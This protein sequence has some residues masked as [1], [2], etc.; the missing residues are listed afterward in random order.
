MKVLFIRIP[1]YHGN[2]SWT[3]R[4]RE[5]FPWDDGFTGPPTH[6]VWGPY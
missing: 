2:Q 4:T 5:K 1:M 3:Y 6:S